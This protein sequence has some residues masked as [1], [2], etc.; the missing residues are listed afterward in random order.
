MQ[1]SANPAL[2]A[3]STAGLFSTGNAPGSPRQ[4]GQT[5][6]FGGAPKLVGHP[7]KIF[8][9]V[10]SWTCTSSPITGSYFAS[11][12]GE[13]GAAMV[14]DIT[15][16]IGPR[17]TTDAHFLYLGERSSIRG[18]STKVSPRNRRGNT[19]KRETMRV[20]SPHPLYCFVAPPAVY[21]AAASPLRWSGWL[22]LVGANYDLAYCLICIGFLCFWLAAQT[23]TP[24]A[25]G[26]RRAGPGSRKQGNQTGRGR[27]RM[28]GFDAPAPEFPGAASSSATPKNRTHSKFR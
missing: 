11:T 16:I 20:L 4:T 21:F 8:V 5:F 26:A 22:I 1:F 12:S 24:A 27:G 9:R 14:E 23:A 17:Q 10:A 18:F 25:S 6:W 3:M 28:Q 7:Q 13:T 15:S 19:G 2:M